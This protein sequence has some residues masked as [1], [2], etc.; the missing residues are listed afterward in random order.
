MKRF[1][2]A[3]IAAGIVLLL[4]GG[5]LIWRGVDARLDS[6]RPVTEQLPAATAAPATDA[7]TSAPAATAPPDALPAPTAAPPEE[8]GP[9]PYESPIDFAS[10]QETNPDIYG[11]LELEGT[12]ISYPV[13]QSPTDDTYYLNHNSDRKYA[14]RGAIFSEH[15]YNS[16]DLTDPVT[17]FYGHHMSSGAMFGDLQQYYA[18]ASFFAEHD[19]LTIYTPEAEY[20]YRIFAAVPWSGEHLLRTYDFSDPGVFESFF[21]MAAKTRSLNANFRE[22]AFPAPGDR[23]VILSTC[24]AGDNSRRFLVMAAMEAPEALSADINAHE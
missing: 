19:T 9:A 11:W 10:L 17:V 6:R 16:G 8:T 21:A 20:R 14:S 12:D 2:A 23:V 3:L 24:L 18:S 15:A 4:A 1:P 13:V 7:E 5:F 22:D